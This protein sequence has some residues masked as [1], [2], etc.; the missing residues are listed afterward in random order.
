MSR[1]GGKDH[2]SSF[3]QVTQGTATNERFGHILHLDSGE[4]SGLDSCVFEGVLQ[5]EGV[6]HGRQ[7]SHVVGRVAVHLTVVGCGG[8]S[9]NIS[10]A[11]DDTELERGRKDT[12]DLVG[13]ALNDGVRKVAGGVAQCFARKFEEEAPCFLGVGGGV[14]VVSVRLIFAWATR[15]GGGAR[16]FCGGF[17]WGTTGGH[18][19]VWRERGSERKENFLCSILW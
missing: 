11:D 16:G 3:L 9:P 18:D 4:Y 1:A 10:A 13:E 5:G 7:H 6:D 12:F 19:R 15:D 14:G 17:F 8:A 2:D